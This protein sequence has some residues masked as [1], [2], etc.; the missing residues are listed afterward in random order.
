[1]ILSKGLTKKKNADD[2]PKTFVKVLFQ[3]QTI[4]KRRLIGKINRF[5]TARGSGPL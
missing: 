4:K 3:I 5:H 1:M 2:I